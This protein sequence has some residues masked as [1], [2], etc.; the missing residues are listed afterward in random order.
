MIEKLEWP[1]AEVHLW[2]IDLQ[3]ALTDTSVLTPEEMVRSGRFQ[4]TRSLLRR[5]LGHYLEQPPESLRFEYGVH[6]KPALSANSS[7]ETL[8]FNLSHTNEVALIAVTASAE[9][10]V[11]VEEIRSVAYTEKIARR[12]FSPSELVW[13][14][15]EPGEERFFRLWTRKEASLKAHGAGL[16][17]PAENSPPTSTVNVEA[18]EGYAAAVALCGPIL[19]IRVREWNNS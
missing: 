15:E 9:V 18:A 2:R 17:V 4:Q 13:L 19:P 16:F 5:L 6:G 7:Q 1:Q 8:F 3:S 14:E 10:G 11:D 12:F